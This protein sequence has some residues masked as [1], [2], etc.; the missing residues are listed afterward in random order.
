V[1][2]CSR[3]NKDLRRDGCVSFF[4]LRIFYESFG[5]FS[6]CKE[7]YHSVLDPLDTLDMG[8][9]DIFLTCFIKGAKR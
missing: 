6:A 1:R 7:D 4:G 9:P 2:I 5:W 3:F 8:L